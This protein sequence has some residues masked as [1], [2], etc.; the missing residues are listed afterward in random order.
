MTAK[1]EGSLR[2]KNN[3]NTRKRRNEIEICLESEY[4]F[5]R[6]FLVLLTRK[7]LNI[8]WDLMM[9]P[10]SDIEVHQNS[11][12]MN[13]KEV[14]DFIMTETYSVD[15]FFWSKKN[16]KFYYKKHVHNSGSNAEITDH[17]LIISRFV[18]SSEEW[19]S[20]YNEILLIPTDNLTESQRHSL[21]I[22]KAFEDHY[23]GGV[24]QLKSWVTDYLLVQEALGGVT[25]DKARNY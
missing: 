9:M 17:K 16:M 22:F 7:E 1:E 14:K 4:G 6:E 25:N 19:V 3:I 5:E 11:H 20:L 12:G 24:E 15:D 10:D 2:L 13:W 8:I 23:K 21:D 18:K